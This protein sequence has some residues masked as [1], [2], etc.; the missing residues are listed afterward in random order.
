MIIPKP[1]PVPPLPRRVP[2]PEEPGVLFYGQGQGRVLVMRIGVDPVAGEVLIA[3]CVAQGMVMYDI[4]RAWFTVDRIEEVWAVAT[5]EIEFDWALII[6]EPG[7]EFVLAHIGSDDFVWADLETFNVEVKSG[8]A[9]RLNLGKPKVA[10]GELKYRRGASRN[11]DLSADRYLTDPFGPVMVQK[12]LK[13]IPELKSAFGKGIGDEFVVWTDG[14][15]IT[16]GS[17]RGVG[18]VTSTGHWTAVRTTTGKAEYAEVYGILIAVAH[19]IRNKAKKVTVKSDS[20]LALFAVDQWINGKQNK[21]KFS[22]PKMDQVLGTIRD[23]VSKYP[24]EFTFSWVKGHSGNPGNVAADRMA[25][26]TARRV[27]VGNKNVTDDEARGILISS[28][29]FSEEGKLLDK[30]SSDDL[31]P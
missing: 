29:V 25:R 4:A 14:S 23:L 1:R 19:G 13:G 2:R 7:V 11:A 5:S 10:E 26:L 9:A 8:I 15:F 30:M 3:R 27:E 20:R 18:V 12:D 16:R 17:L 6:P 24:V 22:N 21:V 28:G 31:T